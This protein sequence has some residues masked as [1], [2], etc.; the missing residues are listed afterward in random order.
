MDDGWMN[1]SPL[2]QALL[3]FEDTLLLETRGKPGAKDFKFPVCI[4]I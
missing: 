4:K 2:I 1:S 3:T